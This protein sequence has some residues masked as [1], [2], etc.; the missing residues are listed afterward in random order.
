M[1]VPSSTRH[2]SEAALREHLSAKLHGIVPEFEL[3]E[4]AAL[5]W[6]ILRLKRER[7]AVVLAHNYMEP[8]L[9]HSIPDFVGDSLELARRASETDCDVIVFC[10]VRFMAETAKILNPSRQVL[11]PS[12][13][14]GCSLASSI[15]VE[16]VRRLRRDFPGAPVVAYVNTSAEVKAEADVC[17]TSGNAAAVVESLDSETV[18]FVPDEYLARNVAAE[19]GRRVVVSGNG[20][21]PIPQDRLIAAWPGR[22]EVHELF[23]PDDVAAARRQFPDVAI[24]AHPECS[25]EIVAAADFTGST[26][27][28]IRFVGESDARRYLLLTECSM[29][30]NVAAANPHKE[31]LRLCSHRCPHMAEIT[32]EDT[33]EALLHER[34]QVEVPEPV[35]SRAARALERMLA[36]G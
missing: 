22:C 21:S 34:W 5:A 19:T 15:T 23:T 16:D 30:D 2:A 7:N 31:L 24:L 28:M 4:K 36:L 20:G 35:R 3:R 29:G 33:L 9:Y 13:R 12:A 32:L 8:A 25:P 11:L 6:R 10:G 14:A 1:R 27:A 26:S 17:C 18:V